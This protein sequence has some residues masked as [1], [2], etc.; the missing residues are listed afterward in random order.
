MKITSVFRALYRETQA[1]SGARAGARSD[2][3]GSVGQREGLSGPNG[4]SEGELATFFTKSNNTEFRRFW[5]RRE[6]AIVRKGLRGSRDLSH[7]QLPLS[8]KARSQAA[9]T[10]QTLSF[11]RSALSSVFCFDR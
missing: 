11:S 2:S 7:S 6:L 1:G 8:F 3:A 4:T 5:I 9:K 10:A